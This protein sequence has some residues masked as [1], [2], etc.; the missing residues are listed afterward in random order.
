MHNI[1]IEGKLTSSLFQMID[2]NIAVLIPLLA[3]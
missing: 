1:K 3:A 2:I